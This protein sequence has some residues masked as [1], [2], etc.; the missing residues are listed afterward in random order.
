MSHAAVSAPQPGSREA[1][2]GLAR[3]GRPRAF[4]AAALG[5]PIARSGDWAVALLIVDAFAKLG[6]KSIASARLA[7]LPSEVAATA[8]AQRI[9]AALAALPSE[10][11]PPGC[12]EENLER[13]LAALAERG[14]PGLDAIRQ[15]GAPVLGATND[16][17]PVVD[18]G[19]V[20]AGLSLAKAE[21]GPAMQRLLAGQQPCPPPLLV[22]GFA[23]SV[24]L[25]ELWR[26]SRE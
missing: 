18:F 15:N 9:R 1:L 3:A 17:S 14:V 26:Q 16:G 24:L 22:S 12:A 21:Y 5:S 8:D 6:L 11:V 23:T 25:R 20:I 4:L 19:E 2:I 7:L 13:N 10:L